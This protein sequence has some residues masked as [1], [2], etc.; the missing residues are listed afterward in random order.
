MNLKP[1]IGLEVHVQLK[2]K[3]KMFCACDNAGEEKPTN[4]AICPICLAHPGTLPMPNKT[5]IVWAIKSALALSCEIPPES[6]F[7]RKHYFYPDLPKGYQISQYDQPFGKNGFLTLG[8]ASIRI[9]RLHL[10][11]DAA[12]LLHQQNGSYTIVDFNRAGTPLMEIVTE[13]DIESPE[14]AGELLRELRAIM[15]SLQ[16]SDADMEKGHLRCDANVSLKEEGSGTLN[17][18]TEIKN[19][20]SF[21]AVERALNYEIKRQRQL[22]G[23]G[24][25]PKTQS[26]RGWNEAKGITEEQREKEAAH[27]YR[28][29]P[30]PDI[31]PILIANV[32]DI[33]LLKKEIPELPMQKRERFHGQYGFS[34]A[35]ANM[36]TR[37]Y[38]LADY[39]E[40]VMSE[41]LALVESMEQRSEEDSARCAK[42]AANWLINN[43]AP[44][45]KNEWQRIAISAENFAEFITLIAEGKISSRAG[46]AIL[47]KMAE[48]G[49]D[50]GDIMQT[51]NLAQTHDE[52]ELAEI[53][54]KVIAEN[55]RALEDLRAGKINALKSLMGAVMKETRGRANPKIAEELL[56]KR[57]LDE[58][59]I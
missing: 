47:Q 48:T 29:F 4:T 22:W 16:V 31:P 52:S 19:L 13:P 26:T 49:G 2:T 18:K 36:I 44:L 24:N 54:S 53:V 56:K 7:D 1:V 34:Y 8:S 5:A 51:E 17:P 9:N 57:A 10:E 32:T 25:A 20:N 50:P 45:V 46:Q 41:L 35:D 6:K 55:Q 23:E 30:E 3:S 27:D 59:R 42:L 15:R 33:E 11:E 21:R 28:Y 43:L 38:A 14:M 39:A 40:K 37:D 12:K 58:K